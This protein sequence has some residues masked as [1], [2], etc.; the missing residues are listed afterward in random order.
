MCILIGCEVSLGQV[1]SVRILGT[2]LIQA[3]ATQVSWMQ[4]LVTYN[5]SVNENALMWLSMHLCV[6][7]CMT[8]DNDLCLYIRYLQ[9]AKRCIDLCIYSI[10]CSDL[11]DIIVKLNK[12]GVQVRVIT[13]SDQQDASGSQAGRFRLEG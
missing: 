4:C 5:T 6:W 12:L 10:T 11:A 9:S 3:C 1:G 13:D 2:L 8:D 7:L